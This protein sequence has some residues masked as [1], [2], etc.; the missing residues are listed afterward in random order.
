MTKYNFF[1][2]KWFDELQSTNVTLKSLVRESPLKEYTVVATKYQYAGK[3][4]MGNKW[5]SSANKNL[6][7][8]VLLKPQYVLVQD[9]FIISKAISLAIHR[10]LC[11]LANGFSIKW[12]NDIYYNNKK[13]GGILIENSLTSNV[14]SESVV[15]IGINVNQESFISDAPNPLSLIQITGKEL[16]IDKLLDDILLSIHEYIEFMKSGSDYSTLNEEYINCLF[17]NEGFHLFKDKSHLFYASI[18]GISEYGQLI[19]QSENGVENT[20]AFKEVEF[21]IN[22][23]DSDIEQ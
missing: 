13:V 5:E 22:P 9:Q 7:F 20:Y 12:P 2:I 3:G 1:D 6:T 17:R 4:Q 16:G 14:I 19:L 8:S 11:K 15:G 23:Q 18:K 10:V 21:V